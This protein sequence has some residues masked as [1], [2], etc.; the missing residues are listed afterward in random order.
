MVVHACYP[1]YSG[2]RGRIV[3]Q[4][5]LGKVSIRPCEKNKL[6]AKELGVAQVIE[7]LPSNKALNLIPSTE[8]PTPPKK[9]P[10]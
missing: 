3:V 4:G 6:K 2:G 5:Q 10:Q 1:I 9:P 7:H 8:K